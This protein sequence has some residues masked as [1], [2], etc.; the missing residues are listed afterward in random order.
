MKQATA[1]KPYPR[2]GLPP[3]EAVKQA[4]AMKALPPL[5]A[6]SPTRR[7]K[8][9]GRESPTPAWGYRRRQ[10]CP[11]GQKALPPLGATADEQCR[12]PSRYESPTPAWGYRS[13]CRQNRRRR[14]KPYPRLG[15]PRGKT[16]GKRVPP[17]ALPPLGATHRF[18]LLQPAIGESPTPAWGY[19]ETLPTAAV[20]KRKPYPRLGLPP[21]WG[22]WC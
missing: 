3:D 18:P 12:P 7:L 1:R 21:A 11:A 19:R 8:S 16:G 6:T 5:G 10:P 22:M 15:L 17:K 20:S 2:L 9:W 13:G 14:R 4:T